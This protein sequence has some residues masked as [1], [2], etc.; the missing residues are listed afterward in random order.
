MTDIV[1]FLIR[2]PTCGGF[3]KKGVNLFGDDDQGAKYWSDG[4]K[5]LRITLKVQAFPAARTVHT[6]FIQ[7][8]RPRSLM[9]DS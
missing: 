8:T 1:P 6:F 5:P 7:K 4:K 3:L 2:C 9:K